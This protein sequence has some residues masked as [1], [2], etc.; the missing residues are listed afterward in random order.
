M[1][2]STP[3]CA[4]LLRP[5][6]VALVAAGVAT[7]WAQQTPPAARTP[8]ANEAAAASSPLD[9]IVITARK[10]AEASQSVPISVSAFNA[11]SL[12]RSKIVGAQ[13]LQFSIPNAVLTGNDRFTIRGIG[14]NSLGGD[15]GVG[16]AVNGASIG[17]L[18]QDELFDLERIEVLRGPQGTLFGRNTTGGA[19]AVFTKR[20]TAKQEGNMY[21][22]VGNYDHLRAGGVFNVPLSDSLRQR[23]AAYFLEQGGFTK[24]QFTGNSIDGRKQFSVRSSTRLFV[25]DNTEVNLMIS[26]YSED[27][28]RT[29]ETKRQCKAIA[30][31]GCSPNELGF[32]SP[33]YNATIFRSLAG[34]LTGLG[35]LPAGSN[36]YAGAQNPLDLRQVAAD[37]DAKFVLSGKS[38]TFELNHE[39]EPLSLTWISGWAK[40]NTD[41]RTDWDNAALPFRFT[42]PITYNLTAD[43]IITTDQ[44]RTTDSFTAN[45]RTFTN[46]VRLASRGKGALSY[47]TGLFQLD[48]KG[49]SG[50]FIYHPFFE[51]IQKVQGRPPETWYVNTESRNARTKAWAWFGEAQYTISDALRG[52]LGAR[53]TNEERTSEGRSIVL[54]ALAPFVERTPIKDSHWTSR[55]SLDYTPM[56]DTLIYGSLASGYKGGGFN[57]GST[58]NPTFSPETVK[59]FEAG[60]KREWLDGT[61]RTNLAVFHNDYKNMQLGQRISGAAITA[62]ADATTKGIEF[63]TL[64]APTRAWLID[65]NVSFLRTRIG[66]FLTEDAAN[67]AQSLTVTTPTVQVNLAGNV[68]PHSPQTKIKLGA[69][70]TMG[71]FNNGWTSTLRLD[72]VWQDKY[73][74]REFNTP[75]D[76]IDAWSVTNLQLRIA[77]PKEGLEFKAYVKNLANHNNITNI[78]I[79]DPLV[80]RYRNVRLLDPR[81]FGVQVQYNF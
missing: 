78:I 69:Q 27:S 1:P 23:F 26:G 29:R 51:L 48:S 76:R 42:R 50:F 64:Y 61:L 62:N 8:D 18:P 74:A 81:T 39:F 60:V 37:Y 56:K 79:E 30:V 9:S 4:R 71:L 20:P 75:T 28:S 58:N 77:N 14:N 72:H 53:Y 36:I 17:Y 45:G 12:E 24:N 57:T 25:G 68:L 16:L 21:F 54:A 70:Y 13:D 63:E 66:N 65:A 80:G 44:L 52:T 41:Q 7:A 5:T 47:T 40:T 3:A 43:Q 10:R 2:A 31:L 49:G 15:N 59:A 55:A 46:E 34:P 38:V 19:L 35:Y 67:P 6:L 73:F 32:D 33:D 11:D 22:E